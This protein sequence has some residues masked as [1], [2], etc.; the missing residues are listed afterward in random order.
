MHRRLLTYCVVSIVMVSIE[1]VLHTTGM[2]LGSDSLRDAFVATSVYDLLPG[3]VHLLVFVVG[4]AFAR[5]R[6]LDRSAVITYTFWMIF[7]S[8][9]IVFLVR[10]VFAAFPLR[11]LIT[12]APAEEVSGQ[13]SLFGRVLMLHLVGALF[14]PWTVREAFEVLLAICGLA[15]LSNVLFVEGPV[16]ARALEIVLLPVAGAPGLLFCRFRHTRFLRRFTF[17]HVLGRYSQLQRELEEA[18]RIHEMLF[19][20]QITE[21]PL[22]LRYRYEPM[23]QIGGDYLY[24]HHDGA[25]H[26]NVVVIDVT[27]HGITAA[28]TVNRINGELDRL[29]GEDRGRLPGDVLRRLN[30][31][32]CVSIARHGVFATAV[33]IQV[34]HAD[35]RLRWANAGHPPPFVLDANGG[36]EQLDSNA[37]MLGVLDEPDYECSTEASFFGDGNRIVLYT[38]G[39]IESR[40]EQ[41]RMLGIEG[42]RQLLEGSVDK[43]MDASLSEIVLKAVQRFRQG[44]AEDDTLIVEVARG[45]SDL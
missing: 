33:A 29:F 13:P 9:T 12:D 42:V 1:L 22:R 18:R 32:F 17:D 10:P 37:M 44:A 23:Q 34:D 14:I 3:T 4:Y 43:R 38:D 6:S 5:K 15:L 16:G 20:G 28:L 27:G 19:P 24:V 25:E 39:V 26:L 40:D 41:D 11:T 2:F 31:Y 35:G 30:R 36:C 45:S 7:A 8:A 21:G